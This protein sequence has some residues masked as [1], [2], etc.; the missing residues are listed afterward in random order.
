MGKP[1]AAS[2][3]RTGANIGWKLGRKDGIKK[4]KEK[5]VK[6][7]DSRPNKILGH[8]VW[9]PGDI[10]KPDGLRDKRHRPGVD[11]F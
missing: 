1:D 3:G 11:N 2:H 9:I 5:S 8:F 4:R 7:D 10:P 6:W